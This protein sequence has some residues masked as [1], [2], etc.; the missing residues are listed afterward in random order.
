MS[1]E[2]LEKKRKREVKI[3][4]ALLTAGK[5]TQIWTNDQKIGLKYSIDRITL[6]ADLSV[7][8]KEKEELERKVKEQAETIR[9]Q[10]VENLQLRKF[11]DAAMRTVRGI[12]RTIPEKAH[13]IWQKL[14]SNLHRVGGKTFVHMRREEIDE[15]NKGY[16]SSVQESQSRYNS[17]HH[18]LDLF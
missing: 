8:A 3:L 14:G 12:A 6:M 4:P 18:D 5:S 2:K 10:Q 7:E 13:E 11:A 1:E 15:A 9:K 16:Q 17:Q